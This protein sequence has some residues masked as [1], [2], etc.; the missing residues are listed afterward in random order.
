MRVGWPAKRF[1]TRRSKVV[2][3]AV[4]ALAVAA[5]AGGWLWLRPDAEAVA[6]STTQTVATSTLKETVTASGTLRAARS[7]DLSFAVSGTV[8]AVLV[9]EGDRVKKGA[10]LA[11]VDATSLVAARTAARSSYDAALAQLDEDV[12]DGASDVQVAADRSSVVAARSSW[13]EAREAVD[14]AVLRAPITGTVV[15][16]DLA[17]G[18]TVGSSSTGA[19]TDPASG[20]DTTSTSTAQVT[21][22]TARTFAVDAEVAAADIDGVK[23]GLQ[24]E[25]TVSGVDETVYG[26]VASVGAVAETSTSGA[27]VFPVVVEVTGRRTD[28]YAGSTADLSII[29]SQRTDVITVPTQAVETEDGRAYV[30]VVVDGTEERRDIEIGQASGASTEVTDGLEV[31]DTVVVPGFTGPGAG[32]GTDR[33]GQQGFPGGTPPSGFPGGQMG[34]MP[35]APQ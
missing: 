9:D 23:K 15:A 31:G 20:S 1:S 33:G 5:S 21:I 28:L 6:A 3:G 22:A 16:L 2:A 4:L 29:V 7:E 26:T 27:A 25:L 19:S 35:G 24:V 34:Q 12:D 30:T 18:D 10:A 17:V 32:N 13:V 11:R 14:D 8:R